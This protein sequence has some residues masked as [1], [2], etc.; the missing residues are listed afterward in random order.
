[1]HSRM[2]K[3][4]V[5]ARDRLFQMDILRHFARRDRASVLGPS[6]LPSDVQVIRDLYSTQELERQYENAFDRF[7]RS[8][9]ATRWCQSRDERDTPRTGPKIELSQDE[10][11]L[12]EELLADDVSRILGQGAKINRLKISEINPDSKKVTSLF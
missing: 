4:N 2:G 12:L 10:Q 11:V 1:M 9:R 6:Q 5:Q 8:C 3:G 7:R